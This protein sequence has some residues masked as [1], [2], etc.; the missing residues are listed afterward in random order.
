MNSNAASFYCST[1]TDSVHNPNEWDC[2]C[3][4]ALEINFELLHPTAALNELSWMIDI[5]SDDTDKHRHLP[6]KLPFAEAGCKGE[7]S[8]MDGDDGTPDRF[9]A[10]LA[11]SISSRVTHQKWPPWKSTRCLC[12]I[13]APFSIRVFQFAAARP[14]FVGPDLIFVYNSLLACRS[15][16]TDCTGL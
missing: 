2:I 9:T 10:A 7:A 15:Q 12:Q 13:I 3:E 5:A 6:W 11:L 4:S 16:I 14:F 1:Q 8:S